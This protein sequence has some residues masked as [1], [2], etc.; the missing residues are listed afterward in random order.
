MHV[1]V[2][3][4]QLDVVLQ[5]MHIIILLWILCTLLNYFITSQYAYYYYQSSQSSSMRTLLLEQQQY[6]T[7]RANWG[8]SLTSSYQSSTTRTSCNLGSYQLV[9]YAYSVCILFFVCILQYGYK[10]VCILQT[11][12]S[13]THSD[14]DTSLLATSSMHIII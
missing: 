12:S 10:R 7:Q 14:S 1:G 13:N 8:G 6:I 5:S 3:Y 11:S 9:L 2:L 4:A